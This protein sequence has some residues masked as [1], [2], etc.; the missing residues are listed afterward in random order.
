MSVNRV[1]LIGRL[2]ADVA[3]DRTNVGATPIARGSLACSES[4]QDKK[5]REWKEIV[6]WVQL[7]FYD[8]L[9]EKAVEKLKKG[10]EVYIEGKIKTW[11]FE[12]G[13]KTEYA[14]AVKVEKFLVFKGSNSGGSN[15]NGVP[16]SV[17]DDYG[18]DQSP[19]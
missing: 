1:I 2:G 14:T 7:R 5:T 13:G 15:G 3:I 16:V 11:K 18:E 6:D 8:R 10:V 12:R 9:A 17:E 4:Y 19:F